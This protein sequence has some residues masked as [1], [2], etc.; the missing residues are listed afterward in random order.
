L[1][2]LQQ[3]QLLT[4][5]CYCFFSLFVTTQENSFPRGLRL[6]PVLHLGFIE[7]T[8]MRGSVHLSIPKPFYATANRVNLRAGKKSQSV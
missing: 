4:L 7:R 3:R 5:V 8:A 6:G 2:Y 1:S